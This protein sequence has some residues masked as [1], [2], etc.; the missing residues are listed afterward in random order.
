[1]SSKVLPRNTPVEPLPW[2]TAAVPQELE[3][4]DI[5]RVQTST[6]SP[7]GAEAAMY[8]QRVEELEQELRRMSQRL[9]DERIAGV[10]EGRQQA[11]NADLAQWAEAQQRMS[12]CI[13]DLAQMR[14]RF[15][16][17]VEEDAIRLSL[18]IARKVIR[19][20]LAVDTEALHGLVRVALERINARDVLAFRVSS[21][22]A[23]VLS[24]QLRAMGLPQEI[25]VRPEAGLP[26]GSLLVDSAQGVLDVSVDTQLKEIERGLVDAIDRHAGGSHA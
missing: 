11:A 8:R 14:P 1:M 2:D 23:A 16:R 18:A 17:E 26:R 24:Q 9:R 7:S 20:E 19:R 6:P 21:S 15:R 3:P 4:D 12:N 25:T 5:T 22:D 13:A 10:A